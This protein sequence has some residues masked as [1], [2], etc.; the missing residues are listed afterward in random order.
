MCCLTP[1]YPGVCPDC[2]CLANIDGLE[3]REQSY[4]FPAKL[5]CYPHQA[6]SNKYRGSINKSKSYLKTFIHSSAVVEKMRKWEGGFCGLDSCQT[7][8]VPPC[9]VTPVTSSL[10]CQAACPDHCGPSP[11]TRPES[12]R[13]KFLPGIICKDPI[14]QV[15]RHPQHQHFYIV[16]P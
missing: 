5:I 13:H 2:C 15:H 16:K 14:R 6:R 7:V 11:G 12:Y 3:T 8:S 10:V 4:Q 1:G 9:Q